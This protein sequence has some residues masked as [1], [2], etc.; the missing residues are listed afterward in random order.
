MLELE[1][2][3]SVLMVASRERDTI[4]RTLRELGVKLAIDDF[5]TGYSSLD[6]L[7]RF[8]MD[9]LKISHSFTRHIESDASNASI[10][11][12]II[13]LAHELNIGMI[14][15]GVE[16]KSQL[17]LL[18]SW[19]CGEVQGYYFARP[20][21]AAAIASLLCQGATIEPTPAP[22]HAKL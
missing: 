20:M 16:T 3:E 22:R 14:V 11:R 10:V 6:Y 15:E 13:G 17:E 9:H 2:T 19:N 1:L 21:A 12:A 7:R 5:G 8:P 4:L 18:R